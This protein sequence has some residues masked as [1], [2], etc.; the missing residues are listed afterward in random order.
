MPVPTREMIVFYLNRTERHIKNVQLCSEV[1]SKHNHL[2]DLVYITDEHDKSK[3][4]NEEKLPYIWF[5]WMKKKDVVL[6]NSIKE[7]VNIKFNGAWKHHLS[8]NPHHPE[9]WIHHYNDIR[10]MSDMAIAEYVCDIYGMSIEFGGSPREFIDR[11]NKGF[12]FDSGQLHYIDLL[13]SD[14]EKGIPL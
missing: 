12:Q 13:M 10:K 9:Y 1:V 6:D 4:S 3:F 7:I 2:S 11:K 8:K 14:L 5:T